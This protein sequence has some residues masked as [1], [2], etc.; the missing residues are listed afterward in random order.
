MACV[1][2]QNKEQL[3]TLQPITTEAPSKAIQLNLHIKPQQSSILTAC[4]MSRLEPQQLKSQQRES[5]QWE[6][7]A[8]TDYQ[9]RKTSDQR[10]YQSRGSVP[11]TSDKMSS[12]GNSNYKMTQPTK[13]YTT[14]TSAEMQAKIRSSSITA[15]DPTMRYMQV[16][17]K[18]KRKGGNFQGSKLS[19]IKHGPHMNAVSRNGYNQTANNYYDSKML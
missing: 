1:P 6:M 9:L 3:N 19:Q 10:A 12:T 7:S 13:N 17:N 2:N 15:T 16:S 4:R 11:M 8:T 18:I 14:S 5:G